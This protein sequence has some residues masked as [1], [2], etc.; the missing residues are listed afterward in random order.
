MGLALVIEAAGFAGAGLAFFVGYAAHIG[1]DLL[2]HEGCAF[3]YPWDRTRYVFWPA[4]MTGGIAEPFAALSIV[5]L[6]LGTAYW[7]GPQTFDLL[8]RLRHFRV[9]G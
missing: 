4:V 8:S 2:T 5:A 1:A 6:L 3:L 9:L 7:L